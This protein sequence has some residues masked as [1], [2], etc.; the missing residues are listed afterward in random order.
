[1]KQ[2]L[3]GAVGAIEYLRTS[4]CGGV[5][6]TCLGTSTRNML[7][8]HVS[9]EPLNGSLSM[10]VYSVTMFSQS[11]FYTLLIIFQFIFLP[12]MKGTTA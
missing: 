1:M 5:W 3:G 12:A 7:D 6:F 4:W 8:V 9:H 2:T 11:L 10:D